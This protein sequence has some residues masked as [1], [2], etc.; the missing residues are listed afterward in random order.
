MR[1]LPESAEWSIA[2]ILPDRSAGSLSKAL[3]EGLASFDVDARWASGEDVKE[4]T[5]RVIV[6]NYD[7]IVGLEF[8]AVFVA[9]CDDLFQERE[10]ADAYQGLWVALTRARQYLAVSSVGVFKV[11]AR[12]AFQLYRVG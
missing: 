8:D 11:L 6:T 3:I 10:R 5:E 4:S 1:N 9:A 7:S 2:V 12:P